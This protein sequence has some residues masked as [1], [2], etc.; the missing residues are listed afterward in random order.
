VHESN[1]NLSIHIFTAQDLVSRPIFGQFGRKYIQLILLRRPYK[2]T[3]IVLC[4]GPEA[5]HYYVPYDLLQCPAWLESAQ[6]WGSN[7]ILLPDVDKSIG[8]ALVHYLYTGTYQTLD[9]LNCSPAE[10]THSEF[11]TAVLAYATAK[12]HELHGLE[13]LA[14]DRIEH[15]GAEIDIHDVVETIK[16][17]YSKLLGDSTWFLD[18]LKQKAR[19]AFEVDH[20]VFT[21][22]D[23]FGRIDDAALTKVLAKCVMEL[24][25]EKVTRMLDAGN[26]PAPEV[27]G[28]CVSEVQ[29][30]SFDV[31]TMEECVLV[32]DIPTS[33]DEQSILEAPAEEPLVEEPSEL[34]VEE[35]TELLIEEPVDE[36]FPTEDFPVQDIPV[37]E[38]VTTEPQLDLS[39]ANSIAEAEKGDDG[40]GFSFGSTGK[41]SKK[42]GKKIT[43]GTLWDEPVIIEAP[44]PPQAIPPTYDAFGAVPEPELKEYGWD[45]FIESAKK[46]KKKKGSVEEAPLPPPLELEPIPEPEP[47]KEDDG[48]GSA[49]G[50]TALTKKKKGKKGLVEEV[51]E[52]PKVKEPIVEEPLIEESAPPEPEPETIPEPEPVSEPV[53]EPEPLPEDA[54]EK[55]EEDSWGSLWGARPA[56]KKKG[57]KGKK[58]AIVEP[59]PLEPEP[60]PELESVQEPEPV[61]E[62]EPEKKKTG[63]WGNW[64][65]T[66]SKKKKKG[67]KG[68]LVDTVAP[69]PDL[70]IE[71]EAVPEPIE[72]K[73]ELCPMCARRLLDDDGWGT[74]V[75]CRAVIRQIVVREMDNNA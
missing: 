40:W 45:I 47:I 29:D 4:F 62:I 41:K 59:V 65:P 17:D 5:E 69:E 2:S 26:Q 64:E 32:E 38:P 11:K 25:E 75:K 54:L 61:L 13:E 52:E 58:E 73:F 74:C 20:T 70:V 30:S 28:D 39:A 49:W 68:A 35:P 72:I 34:L 9:D 19:A 42:N 48:W 21:K 1:I 57:K 31:A 27:P 23:F 67:E 7:S 15:F 18:Y 56:S 22:V 51:R 50:A 60:I 53:P 33:A 46:K 12:K 71:P 6:G 3:T 37:E 10:Q 63:M 8:H 43:T 66:A 14:K 36:E 16:D 24:Y 44:Q 55:K